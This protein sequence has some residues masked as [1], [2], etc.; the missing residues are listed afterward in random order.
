MACLSREDYGSTCV[1]GT[2]AS[3]AADACVVGKFCTVLSVM[4]GSESSATGV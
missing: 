4:D 2:S 1:C 3:S